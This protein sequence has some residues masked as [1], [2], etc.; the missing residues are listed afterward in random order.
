[1]HSSF[2]LVMVRQVP[3]RLKAEATRLYNGYLEACNT[4]W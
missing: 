4:I 2:S 3:F 1:M